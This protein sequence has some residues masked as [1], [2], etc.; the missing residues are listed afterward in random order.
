[1]SLFD[2]L[3]QVLESVFDLIPRVCH[4][5]AANEFLVVDTTFGVKETRYAQ[6]Y[7]PALSHVEYYPAASHPIDCGIQS[8]ITADNQTISL[9]ISATVR[10]FDPLTLRSEVAA[11]DWESLISLLIRRRVLEEAYGLN[12][13]QFRD[14]AHQFIVSDLSTDLGEYGIELESLTIED[15][16]VAKHFRF[17]TPLAGE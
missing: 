8:A 10:I 3:G 12:L 17:L 4:R 13:G 16:V 6:F 9:S 2:V 1:M 7:V 5:P 11:D 15:L 14:S